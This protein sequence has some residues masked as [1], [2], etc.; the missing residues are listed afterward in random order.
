MYIKIKLITFTSVL[1][2]VFCGLLPSCNGDI[3]DFPDKQL[4]RAIR[5]EIGEFSSPITKTDLANLTRLDAAGYGISD[6]AGLEQCTNL[7]WLDIRGNYI[8]NITALSGL[9]KLRFLDL[10][11][12]TLALADMSPL[13]AITSLEELKLQVNDITPIAALP[14]LTSLTLR[15]TANLTVLKSLNNLTHLSISHYGP[16]G[17]PYLESYDFSFME[18]G[19]TKMLGLGPIQDLSFLSELTN[20]T[21]LDLGWNKISD[22]SPL[23]NLANLKELYL[24]ANNLTDVSPLSTMTDLTV[25]DLN[26]N[27][28]SDLSPLTSLQNL[29]E[30]YL[31]R[32][33]VSD[34]TSLAD[35]TSLKVLYL[36]CSTGNLTPLAG[37][38]GL[39]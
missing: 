12:N 3:V 39:D 23:K 14:N 28:I 34:C 21:Y 38:L 27:D 29:E 22:L 24:Y 35:M 6:L 37:L 18:D 15:P 31:H 25:L 13:S 7:E 2:L 9:K 8:A 32:N 17:D 30:L 10:Y 11:Y 19:G 36:S 1:T 5:Y 4:E 26:A 20:L 16:D 33:S